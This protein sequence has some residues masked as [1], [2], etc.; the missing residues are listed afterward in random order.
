MTRCIR[1]SDDSST[2]PQLSSTE[3][4]IL[5]VMNGKVHLQT[6]SD[7]SDISACEAIRISAG[8]HPALRST[9]NTVALL[10]VMEA[11]TTTT[12]PTPFSPF[13]ATIIDEVLLSDATSQEHKEAAVTLLIHEIWGERSPTSTDDLNNKTAP[14]LASRVDD[15]LQRQLDTPFT[16]DLLTAELRISKP[17]LIRS[18]KE[19]TGTTPM[20]RLAEMRIHH[21]KLLLEQ[22]ELPIA[23]IAHAVGYTHLSA[24]SHFFKRHTHLSPAD[25]RDN[26]RWLV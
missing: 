14:T 13:A 20:Q 22:S 18:Y 21:A 17:H 24:F 15:I 16:L 6:L 2:R 10:I 8:Q 9:P 12:P 11:S 19:A 7:T 4:V 23:Q 26:C 5:L 3:S 1:L 25:Y